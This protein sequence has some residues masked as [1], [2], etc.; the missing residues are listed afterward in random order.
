MIVGPH[1]AGARREKLFA[2]HATLFH[3]EP[4]ATHHATGATGRDRGR[5]DKPA[6]RAPSIVM[7]APN[8]WRVSGERRAEGDE[9]VRCTG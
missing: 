5:L 4:C 7:M 2:D 6:R 1:R 3:V 8:G 9:R